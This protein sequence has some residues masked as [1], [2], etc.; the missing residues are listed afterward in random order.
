MSAVESIEAYGMEKGGHVKI[1]TNRGG[2]IMWESTH[3]GAEY[4]KKITAG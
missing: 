4:A 2:V 3:A 1:W